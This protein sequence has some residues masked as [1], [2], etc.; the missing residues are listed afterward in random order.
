MRELIETRGMLTINKV[1]KAESTVA[2]LVEGFK[3]NIYAPVEADKVIK[4]IGLLASRPFEVNELKKE[5]GN[6]LD[7]FQGYHSEYTLCVLAGLSLPFTR[8]QE[9]KEKVKESQETIQN[10]LKATSVNKLSEEIDFLSSSSASSKQSKVNNAND[11][12]AKYR[13]K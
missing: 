4:Y 6:Y 2:K 10:N 13:K 12:F 11:I 8:L 9:M 1:E 3:N 5:V 7:V